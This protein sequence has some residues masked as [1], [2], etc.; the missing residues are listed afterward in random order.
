MKK[1]ISFD[2]LR[3]ILQSLDYREKCTDDAHLFHRNKT[4]LLIFRRYADQEPMDLS[5]LIST[6]RFLDMWG[7]MSASKFDGL[8]EQT[9]QSA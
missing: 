4:D 1:A 8:V 9:P 2:E 7:L 6:R 5:D 3:R